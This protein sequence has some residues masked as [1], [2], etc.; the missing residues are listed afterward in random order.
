MKQKQPKSADR[1]QNY[2]IH[3]R[4]VADS[5]P[6]QLAATGK[7]FHSPTADIWLHGRWLG[8]RRYN[9]ANQYAK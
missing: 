7:S 2:N 3:W 6:E 8:I 5:T 1:Q 9:F 4:N